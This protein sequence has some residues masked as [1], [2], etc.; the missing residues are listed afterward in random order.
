MII[1]RN[2]FF[3]FYKYSVPLKLHDDTKLKLRNI[4][5]MRHDTEAPLIGPFRKMPQ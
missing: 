4:Q 1:T 2:A 3:F 5:T